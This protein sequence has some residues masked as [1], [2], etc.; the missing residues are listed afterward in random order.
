VSTRR[1][2]K[3]QSL[4][5]SPYLLEALQ[6]AY[7]H[8]ALEMPL[9]NIAELLGKSPATITRRLDEVRQ[10][11]WLRDQPQFVPPQDVWSELQSH[12]TC[13]GIEQAILQSLG[14]GMLQ[15]LFVL[16]SPVRQRAAVRQPRPEMVERVG[17]FAARRLSDALATS[18]H[19]VGVN[20]GW[21]VRHCMMNLRPL[22]PNPD[23]RFVPLIGNL[24]L[25][26]SDPHY[27]EAVECS[28][29][30]LAQ[31][32][33]TAFDAPRAPRLSTPAY[34]PRRFHEDAHGLRAI[35]DFIENDVS[36]RRVFGA[37]D[38]AGLHHGGLLDNVDT[39]V[40]G[41][42]SLDVETLPIYRPHLITPK[43]IPV[44]QR[45]GVQG[46]IALNLVVAPE[47]GD[48]GGATPERRLVEDINDLIVGA[49]PGDFQ[50]VAERARRPGATGLGVVVLSAGAWKA[51][52]LTTA[53]RMGVVN[54]LVTD[55]ETA[56][57]IADELG[58]RDKVSAPV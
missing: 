22:R 3:P 34:I 44:L 35:R 41:L 7:Y 25:D 51:G 13:S 52:I 54:E 39:L 8:C 46:D 23:L 37:R 6:V 15:R 21:S 16:P 38:D 14:R 43:D 18:E 47:D 9:K 49:S 2:A 58:I 42:T 4:Q 10:A 40:T 55:L 5:D 11:G 56:Y 53:I 33:A 1:R 36:Y 48:A 17:L 57:A 29:N 30:R 31:V 19:V 32:A 12:M 28:S 20:W 24:S 45:A 26:E 50:Q 27:E